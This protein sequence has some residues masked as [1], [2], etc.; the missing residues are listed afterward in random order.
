MEEAFQ[1]A[2]VPEGREQVLAAAHFY[3]GE[4][5]K[6]WAQII[7]QPLGLNLS[8]FEELCSALE[9]RFIP[10]D[11]PKK[12][13]ASWTS[14][15]QQGTIDEYMR[16]VDE[17][18]TSHPMGLEGE[19]WL[20]WY[21]L[22][23]ELQAEVRYAL[24]ERG[25]RVC[26]RYELRTILKD[27]E[28]KYPAPQPKRFIPRPK[29]KLVEVQAVTTTSVPP[30]VCWICDKTGH[31]ANECTRR[32]PTGCARCGSKAHNLVACPQR[33]TPKKGGAS[34]ASGGSVSSRSKPKGHNT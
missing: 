11:A 3:E 23:P 14:L 31:R 13:M 16:R 26:S 22:R 24:R 4:A 15:R 7:G 6:W 8:S 12:A 27:L 19:F 30:S 10:Q 28:V 29:A 2:Q 9:E 21:G 34:G 17:L 33:L 25:V 20:A 32:K 18:A 1:D 5:S